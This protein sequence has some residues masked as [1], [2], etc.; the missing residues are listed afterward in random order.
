MCV[1]LF[2]RVFLV[3]N[4]VKFCFVALLFIQIR[5]LTEDRCCFQ[6]FCTL[7]RS[8]GQIFGIRYE[9]ESI[10]RVS[11]TERCR[12]VLRLLWGQRG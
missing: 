12:V 5:R 4:R 9:V 1:C 2:E 10:V 8:I 3:R 6:V 11:G 7:R